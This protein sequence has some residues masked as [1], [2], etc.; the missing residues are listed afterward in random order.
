MKFLGMSLVVLGAL[1][2]AAPGLAQ[3]N[4]QTAFTLVGKADQK[5]YLDGA[6]SANPTI[7]IAPS[8]EITITIKQEG[9]LPHNVK[10]S[11]GGVATKTSEIT[12]ED[13]ETQTL[14]FSSPAS[15]EIKYECALHP[16]TMAGTLRVAGTPESQPTNKSPGVQVVGA[17][18]ALAG[19]A[20]L[21]RRR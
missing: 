1:L 4:G 11:G 2:L 12:Q 5:W 17:L 16:S 13:G 8:S 19:V 15:G 20:L 18:L 10:V 9:N 14:T 6:G 3:N 21:L 7:T